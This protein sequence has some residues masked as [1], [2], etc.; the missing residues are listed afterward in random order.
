MSPDWND[1][2][3]GPSE[4]VARRA[5]AAIRAAVGPIASAGIGPYRLIAK[6]ASDAR[7]PYGLLEPLA[8]RLV[9]R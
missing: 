3:V 6:L 4:V 7:K 8:R 1:R 5:K 2:S 9:E